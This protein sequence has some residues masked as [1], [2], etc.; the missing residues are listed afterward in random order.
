MGL[1]I[2]HLENSRSFRIVWLLNELGLPYDIKTYPRVNNK[3]PAE[4][5]KLNDLGKAPILEDT[6][7]DGSTMQVLE[8]GNIAEYLLEKAGVKVSADERM[9]VH[10]SEGTMILHALAITYARWSLTDLP[11]D[12]PAL[13]K[14][15]AFMSQNVVND[16]NYVERSLLKANPNHKPDDPLFLV[17]GKLSVA[18]VMMA[19]SVEFT[20]KKNLGVAGHSWPMIDR[21][22]EGLS[23]RPA[24]VNAQLQAPHNL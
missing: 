1:V 9:W 5:K 18:D 2:H 4:F 16:L 15:E 17:G 21:W 11:A 13:D 6:L 3:A 7:E 24:Y 23:R 22:L 20:M 8:S 14:C 19:F 10:F 12:Q